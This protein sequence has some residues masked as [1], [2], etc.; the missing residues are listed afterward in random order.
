MP[1]ERMHI[2]QALAALSVGGSE[3][4]T[5]ELATYFSREGHR[6]T[7]IGARGPLSEGVAAEGSE[8][9]EWPIGK[10]RFVT[11]RYVRRLA[12]WLDAHQPQVLHA[13]S[14]LP[15]WVCRLALK[16]LPRER[17]P[18][19]VTSVH[20]Q[21]TV[22]PYSAVMARGDRVIAVS[23]HIRD[24]TL[25]NYPFVNPA[26]LAVIPG[27]VSQSAFPYGH[28]PEA[29]WFDACYRQ[30]PQLRG[31]RLLLLPARLS[32]Y[33][34][35]GVF[36]EL[37]AALASE[38]PDIHG[39]VVGPGR[40]GSRYRAELEGLAERSGVIDHVTFTGLRTDMRDW[41]AAS[42]MVFNLTSDPPEA[43]G[44]TVVE[45]LH[46]G[47]PVIAWNHGGV[48]ESLAVMF[49]DG[50]VRPDSRSALRERTR[51]FLQTRP[52]VAP[53]RE[54]LLDNSLRET[55]RLYRSALEDH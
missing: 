24:H 50:A 55:L 3:L 15:A 22:S 14:R 6:V 41:M 12:D 20:G 23:R 4:V 34:G 17:R 46:L 2:V 32:R 43:F 42:A 47:I 8:T 19:F 54:F 11:L 29:A 30:F 53:S 31:K 40:P 5:A 35:H 25:D 52:T 28:Q 45:A 48:R 16:R 27:G 37:L 9:L 33:K 44:R 21:Y 36:I 18:V 49:P 10:K 26:H 39:V 38:F 1:T 51:A 13:H 7:V